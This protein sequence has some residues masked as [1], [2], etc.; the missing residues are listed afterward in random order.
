MQTSK[1]ESYT[2]LRIKRKRNEEPLD[3]LG[4]WFHSTPFRI[5]TT[6]SIDRLAGHS[7]VE[8]RV[9]R[10]KSRGGIGV[11]QYAQTVEQDA[12]ND[13][14]QQRHLRVR[15]CVSSLEF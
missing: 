5:L 15:L 7:V 6:V 14:Q 4:M 13:V 10:K 11:F 8:S 3:A 12:W 1:P 9:R 2:I